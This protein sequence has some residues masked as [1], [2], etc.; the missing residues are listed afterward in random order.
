MFSS[1]IIIIMRPLKHAVVSLKE[2]KK[3]TP[4]TLIQPPLV[5]LK[6]LEWNQ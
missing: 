6:D 1:F 5:T 2:E 3:T 4:N